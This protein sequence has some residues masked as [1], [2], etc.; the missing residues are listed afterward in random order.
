MIAMCDP[1]HMLELV[2]HTHMLELVAHMLTLV[3][4]T[5]SCVTHY[6]LC[7]TLVH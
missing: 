7:H 5:M 1:A 6:E 3:Y 2:A 4:Q